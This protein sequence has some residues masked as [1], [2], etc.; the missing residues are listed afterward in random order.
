MEKL[1]RGKRRPKRLA[2]PS[3]VLAIALGSIYATRPTPKA[4]QRNSGPLTFVHSDVN[5][6]TLFWIQGRFVPV[7]DRVA[8]KAARRS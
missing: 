3:L 2:L 7:D 5:P 1:E 6:K 8:I 4:Q